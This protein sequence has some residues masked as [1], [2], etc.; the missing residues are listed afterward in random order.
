MRLVRRGCAYAGPARDTACLFETTGKRRFRALDEPDDD[1][2][3]IYLL[4]APDRVLVGTPY[5]SKPKIDFHL[6]N[7]AITRCSYE[8]FVGSESLPPDS[9]LIKGLGKWSGI[10]NDQEIKVLIDDL[11]RGSL[12]N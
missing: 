8:F 6:L 11:E 5:A 7:R 9:A 12:K 4:L 2:H 3:G 1:L 10:L